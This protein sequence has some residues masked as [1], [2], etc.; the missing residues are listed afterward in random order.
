MTALTPGEIERG[1]AENASAPHG[2][3]RIAHAEALSA[4]AEASGDRALFR[5]ALSALI[6]AYEYSAERTKMMVPFARLLQEY[7]RDPSAFAAHEVHGLYWRFKWVTGN[8]VESPEIPLDAVERWLAEMERRYRLAGHSERAVRQAEFSLADFLGDS[9]RAERAMS[10]WAAA[11][12]DR[13][14]DCHACELSNQGRYWA[15]REEDAK[16]VEVWEPVLTGRKTC[17]EEPHRALAHSLLS[18][19]RMG[20]ADEARSHHLRGY[21]MARGNESLLRAVGEHIEFCAL[22]GNESRGLEI[23]SEHTAHLGPLADAEAQLEFNGGILVLLRRLTDLGHGDRPAV[24]YEGVGRTVR[25]L[26]DL[27]YGQVSAIAGRFDVRNGSGHV[28]GRLAER[29]ARRPLTDALPLGVRSPLLPVP[30]AAAGDDAAGGL[31]VP[32]GTA[33]AAGADESAGAAELAE[34]VERARAS[35]T[36]GHPGATLLW[37]RVADRIGATGAEPDPRLA[38]DLLERRALHA[39]RAGDPRARALFAET[40]DAYRTSGQPGRAVVAELYAAT[41]AVQFG[42]GPEEARELLAGVAASARALDRSD[43]TRPR[44]IATV[45]FTRIRIE[46]HLRDKEAAAH[47]ADT[48]EGADAADG[49]TAAD[50]ADRPQAADGTDRTDGELAR[51]LA[52]FIDRTDQLDGLQDLVAGAELMLAGLALGEGEEARA[53]RLLDSAAGRSLSAGRPW[54]AVEPL[55][56]RAALLFARGRAEDAE[57]TARAAVGH[58]G[59][60]T[61]PEEQGAVR[62]TLADILLRRGERAEEAAGHALDAAHWFDQAGL[63]AA[64]GATARLVLGRA[65]GAAGRTAEAAEV[66]QSA[67]PDL[68]KHG[69]YVAVQARETLGGLL[70][71]LRD[72]RG[73]SEQYLLAAETA[74]GWD[75]PGAQAHFAQLAAEGLAA[76]GLRTEAEAAYGRALELWRRIGDN[77]V[78]EV[79]VLR[80]L[81]WLMVQDDG[82]SVTATVP[83]ARKLMEQAADV[84]DGAEEPGLRYERAQTWQQLADLVMEQFY[85][86]DYDGSDEEDSTDDG[87]A[88][89]EKTEEA[90]ADA[91]VQQEAIVLWERAAAVYA[92]L[93]P[94]A[95][96]SRVQCLTR[97][98]WSERALD[99]PDAALARLTA[100]RDELAAREGETA[101]GLVA[102]V[103]TTL[104]HMR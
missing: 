69:D 40:L 15:E 90:A 27:L 22:T 10:A 91:A 83:R 23:L 58:A 47:G 7:D 48:A 34:L 37:D 38:A 103:E 57:T 25:E 49:E 18:L 72:P 80:S 97:A 79:R 76:A 85:D 41:S 62:L 100:L 50:G 13:M 59:E 8:I 94:D 2:A 67:L 9:G 36:R 77:P 35:R 81:A 99:R 84:L 89:S 5:R 42:A 101:R 92:G 19:V 95:L 60:L 45:E 93:G 32:V 102:E 21:R 51:E 33:G 24:P 65:Y 71:D 6:D 16:A 29:L 20:R 44:R 53:E 98:A 17:M 61:D 31:S 26:A 11:E 56:R 82:V 68:L 43:E 1:L 3:A 104:G 30:G 14:S 87:Q 52:G 46:A 55:A 74:K 4:A 73:A 70:R 86:Y 66:L 64:G 12:R 54:D 78:G 88:D 28:S 96:D 39:S 75:D 63:G